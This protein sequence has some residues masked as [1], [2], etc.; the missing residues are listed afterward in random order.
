MLLQ[1]NSQRRLQSSTRVELARDLH[2]SL[3]QDLVAIGFQLDLLINELPARYRA[4]ARVI[5]ETVT[6]ATKS[7]RRELFALREITGD[8]QAELVK[9]AAP[10][11]LQING[12]FS[13]L[14]PSVQRV[15][16]EL[17]RNASQHSKGHNLKV[18]ISEHLISVS[19]DGQGMHGI[20]ELVE[21]LGGHMNVTTSKSGT[22]VEIS[23]P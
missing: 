12:E 4:D 2:D 14:N 10:L 17:V 20:S 7:V 1:K 23:L 18:E 11:H 5:R 21:N 9:H 6:T 8:Y 19:D 16:A 3:A 15:I 13:K 22:R